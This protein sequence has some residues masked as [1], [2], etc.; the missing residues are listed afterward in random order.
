MPISSTIIRKI[1]LTGKY[2][3]VVDEMERDAK[4]M[5]HDIETARK[6]YIKK[7]DSKAPSVEKEKEE[8]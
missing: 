2:S 7:S 4:I 8:D 3:D 6:I 1:Y 5:G